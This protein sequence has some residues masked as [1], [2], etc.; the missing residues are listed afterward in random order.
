[1]SRRARRGPGFR[2]S[3]VDREMVYIVEMGVSRWTGSLGRGQLLGGRFFAKNLVEQPNR[4][5]SLLLLGLCLPFFLQLAQKMWQAFS[6][7]SRKVV[8][9]TKRSC[10]ELIHILIRQ[11]DPEDQEAGVRF[12]STYATSTRR[13]ANFRAAG[14]YPETIQSLVRCPVK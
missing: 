1:M 11:C 12:Q 5:S 6:L 2:E 7:C 13:P 10:Q 14:I 9:I 4:G 3:L 8:L